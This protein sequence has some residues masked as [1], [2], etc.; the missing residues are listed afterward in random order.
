MLLLSA[1]Q[2][3]S[4]LPPTLMCLIPPWVHPSQLFGVIAVSCG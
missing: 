2:S 4:F 3:F 1:M